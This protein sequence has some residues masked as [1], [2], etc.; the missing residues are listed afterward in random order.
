MQT[1][2]INLALFPAYDKILAEL[3][4]ATDP[5]KFIRVQFC[6]SLVDKGS[7]WI[8]GSEGMSRQAL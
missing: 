8:S 7:M 2:R 4:F 1:V 3:V 5:I 6:S